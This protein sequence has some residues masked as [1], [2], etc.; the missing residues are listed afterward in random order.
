MPLVTHEDRPVRF[1]SDL[2]KDRVVFVSMMYAQCSD[3]C[4]LMTQNLRRVHEALGSRPGRDVFFYSIT[5]LPE[6]DRP[7]DLKAYAAQNRIGPGWTFL[8]GT[9]AAV[10]AIRMGMGF[11]DP[12][13][14]V[15]ADITQHTGMVRVGNDS[16]Q[17][18]VMAPLLQDPQVILETLMAVD[19]VSRAAGRGS[20][21]AIQA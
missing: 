4:P 12:D 2:V 8:T 6:F 5:L 21:G 3:Q 20:F 13:P 14:A 10:E 1:Y 19:P 9:K 7:A 11:Y 18:W 16:L 15:D 17:R